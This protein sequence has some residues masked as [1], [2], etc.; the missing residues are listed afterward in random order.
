MRT[1]KA[2]GFRTIGCLVLLP[3]LL[4][5][6]VVATGRE[7]ARPTAEKDAGGGVHSDQLSRKSRALEPIDTIAES[8]ANR[9]SEIY[10]EITKS[11]ISDGQVATEYLRKHLLKGP[12]SGLDRQTRICLEIFQCFPDPDSLDVLAKLLKV[13][14][15]PVEVQ[16]V[17]LYTMCL[18]K[19]GVPRVEVFLNSSDEKLRA[20]AIGALCCVYPDEKSRSLIQK[21]REEEGFETGSAI[22]RAVGSAQSRL[23]DI[24]CYFYPDSRCFAW[25][26][27][28]FAGR[29][30]Y[31]RDG[32]PYKMSKV[33]VPFKETYTLGSDP[34]RVFIWEQLQCLWHED[35]Q[36]A[37]KMLEEEIR[38]APDEPGA[39]EV[40]RHIL[41]DLAV[42]TCPPFDPKK[43]RCRR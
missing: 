17:I 24:Q 27:D 41:E 42:G 13:K 3:L 30:R 23:D 31:I 1:G 38:T 25:D 26:S 19:G 14:T 35:P 16:R 7:P 28:S 15:Y 37:R 29:F 34:A 20:A 18:Q 40:A 10:R 21:I 33:P 12:S 39:G 8:G 36:Q 11:G 9:E 22:G 32:S 6:S 5:T 43:A 2:L 4:G